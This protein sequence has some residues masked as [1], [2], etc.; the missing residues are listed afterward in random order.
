MRDRRTIDR[1]TILKTTAA[2]AA[3]F[4]MRGVAAGTEPPNAGTVSTS[5][6]RPR[7]VIFMVADGMSMGVPSLAEPFSHLIREGGR[8]TAW[9]RLASEMTTTHGLFDMASLN[10]LVTDSAAAASAWATG[11]RICNHALNMLPDGRRLM[12]LGLL[13]K[14]KGLG[15]GLVTTT[16][17]THATPAGFV[18]AV[19]DRDMEE[20]I[21]DQYDDVVDVALGGGGQ[22]FD[23]ATRRDRQDR[24][25]SYA[26]HG[27]ALC[28]SRRD[29]TAYTPQRSAKL[30]GVFAPGHLP[31]TIDRDHQPD[32]AA[33]VPTLAEMTRAALTTLAHHHGRAGFLLQVEGG[34]VDHAAHANDAAAML[35]D[36]LAFDDALEVVLE[37]QRDQPDTLVIITTDHGTA[38]PGL[39]GMGKHYGGST[40]RFEALATFDA[41]FD[42]MDAELRRAGPR[43]RATADSIAT[44]IHAHTRLTIE[45]DDAQAIADALVRRPPTSI[46]RQLAG[47][48]GVMGQVLG[49]HCGIQWTGITHT[50]DW[51]LLMATGP[52]SERFRGLRR[53]TDAFTII[54]GLLGIEHHNPAMNAEEAAALAA[55]AASA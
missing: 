17:I 27:Y 29:L 5:H 51:T 45:P 2:L 44:L 50:A 36:Q 26:A 22:F 12:P 21:A 34:R 20:A 47:I 18:T 6:P 8:G 39:N 40:R 38:N 55:R 9:A 14:A 52:G 53:N 43:E 4:G 37:F 32:I 23:P 3:G 10:S 46:N 42:A 16:T 13:V 49:N 7:T 31:F 48:P 25:G 41:S 54:T 1:R 15:L 33:Q 28:R 30:L 24:F 35:H 19:P 11:T